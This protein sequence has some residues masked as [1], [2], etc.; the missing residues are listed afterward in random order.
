MEDTTSGASGKKKISKDVAVP[1]KPDPKSAISDGQDAMQS[2]GSKA[3]RENQSTSE[4][5]SSVNFKA[6]ILSVDDEP[7][8]QEL[9]RA[10]FEDVTGVDFHFVAEEPLAGSFGIHDSSRDSTF[11]G[12][13]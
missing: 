10:I 1:K 4:T 6:R 7:V 13:V 11:C 2:V 12:M 8:N 3:S 5:S 9:L